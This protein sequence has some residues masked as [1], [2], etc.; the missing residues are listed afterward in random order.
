M[1]KSNK[2]PVWAGGEKKGGF[3]IKVN[4]FNMLFEM[5]RRMLY[6]R[7]TSERERAALEKKAG[8]E[9]ATQSRPARSERKNRVFAAKRQAAKF[10]TE[11]ALKSATGGQYQ[12]RSS[13]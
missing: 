6:R 10:E 9:A 7:Q 11:H 8:R 3:F 13:T 1:Q 4:D 5:A 2:R 12:I